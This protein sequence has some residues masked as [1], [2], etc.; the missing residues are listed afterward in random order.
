MTTE[1]NSIEEALRLLD[2]AAREQREELKGLL[3]G[4]FDSLK[5]AVSEDDA[6]PIK[7]RLVAARKRAAEVAANLKE[8]SGEKAKE[9]ACAVNENA[10]QNPWLYVGGAAVGGLLLGYILGNRKSGE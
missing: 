1:I 10:H 6:L 5:C 8:L 7:E 3:K 9:V 2:D 4:N